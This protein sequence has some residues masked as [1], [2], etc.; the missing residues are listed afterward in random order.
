MKKAD[1]VKFHFFHKADV[2]KLAAPG[3]LMVAQATHWKCIERNMQ[4]QRR[5][6]E[7]IPAVAQLRQSAQQEA[8]ATGYSMAAPQG[9]AQ[10][11]D[12]EMAQRVRLVGILAQLGLP[13]HTADRLRDLVPALGQLSATSLRQSI[14]L[15]LQIHLDSLKA[16]VKGKPLHV[17][18][19]SSTVHGMQILAFCAHFIDMGM[20]PV[21]IALDVA[22]LAVTYNAATL[23]EIILALLQ[24]YEVSM[25]TSTLSFS[26]DRAA[27]NFCALTNLK[28]AFPRNLNVPCLAHFFNNLGSNMVLPLVK[29]F[30]AALTT[31]LAYS[32][33]FIGALRTFASGLTPRRTVKLNAPCVTR[34]FSE[35]ELA[36]QAYVEFD[37]LQQFFS[38]ACEEATALDLASVIEVRVLFRTT[39][40]IARIKMELAVYLDVCT[41]IAAACYNASEERF[42]VFSVHRI[43]RTIQVH[44]ENVE[45]VRADVLAGQPPQSLQGSLEALWGYFESRVLA[46]NAPYR[47]LNDLSRCAR[48]LDPRC[49]QPGSEGMDMND[50]ITTLAALFFHATKRDE[51]QL[52][53]QSELLH[54]RVM[55]QDRPI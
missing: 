40:A 21:V 43:I 46:D 34:W 14:P 31:M 35:L 29:A 15:A 26:C 28:A 54:Y 30:V 18:F 7:I 41:P 27:T 32:D 36:Q 39:A 17:S 48:A 10:R 11:S 44:L 24:S 42:G 50:A 1:T 13:V 12:V 16:L 5:I 52:L 25:M 22:V 55:V 37:V 2:K 6:D 45:Y 8:D 9:L 49:M 4:E 33:R 47:A 38:P 53:L 23:Q 51:A 20:K 19:D 3:L